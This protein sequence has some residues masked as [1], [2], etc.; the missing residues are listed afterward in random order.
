MAHRFAILPIAGDIDTDA[1]L[2][3]HDV[4]HCGAESRLKSRLVTATLCEAHSVELDEVIRPR[5]ASGMTGVN[6][7]RTPSHI[8]VS[9][10]RTRV[11]TL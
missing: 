4:H 11:I 10:S 5:Q 2:A 3:S 8:R 7:S 1:L 6:P 9:N